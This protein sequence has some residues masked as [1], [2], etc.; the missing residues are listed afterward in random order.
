MDG[1]E[2]LILGLKIVAM[3]LVMAVGF[4]SRRRELITA[5]S[6]VVLA[7]LCTDITLPPLI[8]MQ[9]VRTVDLASLRVNWVLPLLAI[10]GI[11]LGCLIGWINW[12]L[13]A[14]RPQA[15]VYIFASGMS[16]WIYLPL[17]IIQ[18]IYGTRGL[19]A[20]FLCNLGLQPLFWSMGIAILHGGK[21][22]TQ[23][24]RRIV[25]NPGLIATIAGIVFAVLVI[26]LTAFG[27]PLVQ[28]WRNAGGNATLNE[29][30]QQLIG[31]RGI[32]QNFGEGVGSV[33][34]NDTVW[35]F[36]S[37]ETVAPGQN[38]EVTGVDGATLKVKRV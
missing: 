27:R 38:V 2:P 14:R 1:S 29:R 8:F 10:A 23:A 9:M 22:D 20:L 36:M 32:V 7:R 35:R 12:R 13:F 24:L 28:R 6:T 34:V 33:K 31:V 37:D 17:P 3:F 30:S 19:Q 16:N 5:D 18:A 11:S 21:I 4:F 25:T 15:P 26:G